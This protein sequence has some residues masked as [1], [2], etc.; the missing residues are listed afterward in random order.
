VEGAALPLLH[1]NACINVN[2][3]IGFSIVIVISCPCNELGSG[4]VI[5][6]TFAMLV[7]LEMERC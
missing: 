6:G 4:A 5:S 2:P 1:S 3:M 7:K